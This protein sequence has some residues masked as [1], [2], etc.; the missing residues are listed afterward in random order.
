LNQ[1]KQAKKRQKQPTAPAIISHKNLEKVHLEIGYIP[2]TQAAPLIIAQEKGF[3]AEYGLEVNLKPENSWKEIA[4]GV[5]T[6]KLDAAQMVAGMPLAMTLG[7]GGKTPISMVTAMTLSRNGSAITFSKE[8]FNN[9]VTNLAEFQKTIN[10]DL[11]KT[12]T[13][14]VVHP[15]SMQNLLLRYWLAAGGIEPDIDVSLMTISPEEMVNALKDKKI[16]G[17]CVG[18]P[19][20]THAIA[21][22]IGSI[23][24]ITSELWNGH[25]DKI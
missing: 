1:Q 7:A 22:N 11:D 25:P 2:L 13:L 17:Y 19:W 4:K 5:A 3:F 10:A 24:A 8:L 20:N 16:D 23:I 15:A 14:G 18:E 9:G 12:H 21:E 6:G